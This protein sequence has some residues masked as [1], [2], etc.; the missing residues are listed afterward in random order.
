MVEFRRLDDKTAVLEYRD[1]TRCLAGW[2]L[3][4]PLTIAYV[5]AMASIT[6]FGIGIA[7]PARVLLFC[8]SILLYFIVGFHVW[9]Q[10]GVRFW[11][12]L[13][14]FTMIRRTRFSRSAGTARM[15]LGPSAIAIP[16]ST[17]LDEIE[18]VV[19]CDQ[20]EE[21]KTWNRLVIQSTSGN[22]WLLAIEESHGRRVEA[23]GKELA[24]FLGIAFHT[25]TGSPHMKEEA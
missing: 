10:Y 4:V 11:N 6:L 12:P 8:V 18:S 1:I 17:N 21:S 25:G 16:K 23:V 2:V 22:R 14:A 24:D 7:G 5:G 9:H 3:G 13:W 15:K 20:G 19:Y